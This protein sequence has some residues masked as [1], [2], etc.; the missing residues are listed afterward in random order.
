MHASPQ[1]IHQL[2]DP[3]LFNIEEDSPEHVYVLQGVLAEVRPFLSRAGRCALIIALVGVIVDER[4]RPVKPLFELADCGSLED[5]IKQ[6]WEAAGA[7]SYGRCH[8]HCSH[9]GSHT[10][11]AFACS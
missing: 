4:R 11:L 9:V 3:I 2:E 6:G 1:T 10:R 7:G 5:Y 8:T